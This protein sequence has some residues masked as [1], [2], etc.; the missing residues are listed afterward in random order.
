[1]KNITEFDF[2]L[3]NPITAFKNAGYYKHRVGWSCT[4]NAEHAAFFCIESGEMQVDTDSYSGI[5]R[6]GDVVF[7]NAFENAFLSNPAKTE[8]SYFFVSFFCE[9]D[10]NFEISTVT[11]D[12]NALS[13]FKDI[14]KTHRSGAY[15]SKIKIAE[16]FLKLLHLLC[17]QK[18][19]KSKGRSDNYKLRSTIEYIN[20]NYYKKI[21]PA[22]LS[23]ISG[24]S[25]AHLRRLFT[26][27]LGVS[28]MEYILN[29]KI[30]MAKEILLDAPEKT[31]EEIAELVG[32]C[33][34]SY[35]CKVFKKM[36]G[37]SPLEY[38]KSTPKI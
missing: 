35:L 30:E 10:L 28:P 31:T 12:T 7:I 37:I 19:Q 17:L 33:S 36:V 9:K 23:Q 18:M 20:I 13:L 34:A 24:Y 8:L 26:I 38:K 5:C 22:Y 27:N 14:S 32:F 15:L 4:Q 21:T 1:M 2:F 25:P 11:K 16:L 3:E 6:A 29:K